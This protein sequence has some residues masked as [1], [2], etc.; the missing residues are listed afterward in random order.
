MKQLIIGIFLL[1]SLVSYSSENENYI[2]YTTKIN[3]VSTTKIRSKTDGTIEGTV[4]VRKG[5]IPV[6]EINKDYPGKI[7]TK[8]GIRYIDDETI[9]VNVN[10]YKGNTII[11]KKYIDIGNT[12]ST[13]AINWELKNIMS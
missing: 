4:E 13:K 8:D 6:E 9:I 3:G 5:I 1:A 12:E 2:T 7:R 10:Y 11:S